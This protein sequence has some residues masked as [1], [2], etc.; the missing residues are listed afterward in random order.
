MWAAQGITHSGDRRTAPSAGALYPLEL[1][2][3]TT[4]EVL[5]YLPAEHLAEQWPSTLA[6]AALAEATPNGDVVR[7]AS[8]TFVITG[9]TARTADMYG[10]RATRYV[11]LEAGHAA[12]NLCLQVVGLGLGAV[13]IG[14]FDDDAVATAL[15]LSPGEVAY[16]LIPVGS[17]RA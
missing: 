14:A 3:V 2:A 13:T 6:L 10:A 7:Q 4:G 8:T 12:Q 11:A 9:V 5:H 17:E 1:Y 15:A 16:Y